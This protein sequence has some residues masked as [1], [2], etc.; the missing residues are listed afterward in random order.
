M[1][2]LTGNKSGFTLIE[3]I[4]AIA[5]SGIV[6]TAVYQV[7]TVST[8]SNN[9]VIEQTAA[10]NAL[11]S[12]I[13]TIRKSVMPAKEMTIGDSAVQTAPAGGDIIKCVD[14]VI[15]FDDKIIG[16]A[17]QYGVNRTELKFSSME[18]GKVLRVELQCY[19]KNGGL[20]DGKTRTVDLYLQSLGENGEGKIKSST[21]GSYKN[22]IAFIA[23]KPDE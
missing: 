16:S 17:S 8:R 1:G 9:A 15:Y 12:T 2:K 13:E 6:I 20:L 19:D 11:D 18:N 23:I 5:L 10:I 3:V 4:I 7:L 21:E 22:S 14:N